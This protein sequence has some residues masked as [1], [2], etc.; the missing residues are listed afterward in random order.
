MARSSDTSDGDDWVDVDDES[1]VLDAGEDRGLSP[2][3]GMVG[4]EV[5]GVAEMFDP[6]SEDDD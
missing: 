2:L 5:D 4:D 3:E 1:D 6:A